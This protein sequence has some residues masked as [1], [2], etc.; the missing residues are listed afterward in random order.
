MS[1]GRIITIIAVLAFVVLLAYNT[2]SAQKVVCDVCVE[3]NGQQNCAKASHEDEKSA[4]RSAQT[5]ACGPIT[6]GMDDVI[7]CSNKPPVSSQC[8]TR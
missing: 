6:N 2:L 8:R 4:I 3:F 7:A 1:R 5:T